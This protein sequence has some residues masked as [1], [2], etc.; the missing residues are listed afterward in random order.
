MAETDEP[1]QASQQGSHR[2]RL[3]GFVVAGVAILAAIG[4][5]AIA[6]AGGGDDDTDD[7]G[8]QTSTTTT[9]PDSTTTTRRGGATTTTNSGGT[10]RP[11]TPTTDASDGPDP[12]VSQTVVA[13]Y[14]NAFRAR[15]TEIWSHASGDGNLWDA[16]DRESAPY[17]VDDCL[18]ELDET[19]GEIYETVEEAREAGTDDAN[20]AASSLT[21]ADQFVNSQ[22]VIL[23]LF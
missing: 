13:A 20:F 19:N 9:R 21:I 12:T 11:T 17:K 4:L 15:C 5:V 2:R 18:F 16:E 23:D 8:A 7:A 6:L 10:T 3:I 1:A 22:G 14:V